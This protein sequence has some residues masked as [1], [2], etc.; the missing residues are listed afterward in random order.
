MKTNEIK[1]KRVLKQVALNIVTKV[2]DAMSWNED[3]IIDVRNK[4]N[5]IEIETSQNCAFMTS[6]F[7]TFPIINSTELFIP[8]ANFPWEANNIFRE[9]RL[10]QYGIYPVV[11]I[12][13]DNNIVIT[14]TRR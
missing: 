14:A 12:T 5:Y 8:S 13:N 7:E 1:T 2:R 10:I 6:T 9:K 4:D 3:V 11:K